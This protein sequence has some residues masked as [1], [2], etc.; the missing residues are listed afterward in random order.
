MFLGMY[1]HNIVSN[2]DG[3]DALTCDAND[4]KMI[5]ITTVTPSWLQ[6]Q[7]IYKHYIKVIKL[8]IYMEM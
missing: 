3:R 4:H 5:K 1:Q 6:C 2:L 7:L 8:Y